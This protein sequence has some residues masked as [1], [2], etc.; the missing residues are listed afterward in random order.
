MNGGTI[1]RVTMTIFAS[2]LY[3]AICGLGNGIWTRSTTDGS[4]WSSWVMNGGTIDTIEAVVFNGRLYQAIRGLGNGIWT[5]WT[6]D[7]ENWSPWEPKGGTVDRIEMTEFNTRLYQA[8]RGLDDGIWTRSTADGTTWTTWV[9]NGGTIDAIEMTVYGDRL[10]QAV[11]G[12]DQCIWTRWTTDGT[13]W[14]GWQGSCPSSAAR[15][16]AL[17]TFTVHKAGSGTGTIMVGQQVCGST[18]V[19]LVIPYVEHDTATL[20]VIPDADCTFVRWET[21]AGVPVEGMH[22][23]QPG[24]TVM[25]VFEKK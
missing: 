6:D 11:R 20:E 18:C 16:E 3:Q 8:I 10:Y 2:R 1:D 14:S 24:D 17:E 4:T 23:A 5:R 12:L 22:Y 9:R 19:E 13:T 21:A 7:G 25:A 15:R